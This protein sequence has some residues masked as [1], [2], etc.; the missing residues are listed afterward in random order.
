MQSFDDEQR[1][2]IYTRRLIARLGQITAYIGDYKWSCQ[3]NDFDGWLVC[4]G[5]SLSTTTYSALY[6]AISTN[7]SPTGTPPAAGTFTI[8]DGRGYVSGAVGQTYSMG[9]SVGSYT[10]TILQSEMPSHT[11]TGSTNTG[12][13]HTHSL[14]DPGH[15]HT[16]VTMASG[17]VGNAGNPLGCA[18]NTQA[19]N[20][21]VGNIA[22]SGTG[23]SAVAVAD[24]LH[25]FTT[26]ATG[27][28]T[29]MSIVQ[30]T[31]FVGTLFIF[32]G[33]V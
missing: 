11:H 31:L 17:T 29:A 16:E 10:H 24:H 27:S 12:G 26:G 33:R 30:P 28:G 6:A 5:R 21:S 9:N 20:S 32:A 8:P 4:D 1:F 22:S 18:D 23:I 7:F 14:T 3:A 2:D 25:T 19:K 13:G 15:T